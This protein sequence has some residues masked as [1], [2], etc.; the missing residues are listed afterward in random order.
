MR[1]QI[2]LSEFQVSGLIGEQQQFLYGDPD[3]KADDAYLVFPFDI[4][5]SGKRPDCPSGHQ[6][7]YELASQTGLKPS[8]QLT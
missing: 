2:Q 4:P 8:R 1:Y 3:T 7:N 5:G 6:A